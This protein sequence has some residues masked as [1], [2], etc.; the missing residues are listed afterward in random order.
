MVHRKRVVLHV[1][2]DPHFTRTVARLLGRHGYEVI[3][4]NDPAQVMPLLT[5]VRIEVVLLDVEMPGCDGLELLRQIK[6]YD[7]GIGVI[8]LTGIV[9]LNT[10]VQS[11]RWG[12][13]ACCFKPLLDLKPLL[14]A[15]D[16]A[17][18]KIDHWW[19]S[20]EEL[21]LRKDGKRARKLRTPATTSAESNAG[22]G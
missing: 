1:D 9:T 11:F 2:D 21:S 4:L 5:R 20:L 14:T 12:A 6:T 13:E 18:R 7:G 19:Q 16:A 10:V 15:L 22:V 3:S 17:F 8:M